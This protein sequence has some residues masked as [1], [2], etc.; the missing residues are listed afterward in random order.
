M[1]KLS[2]ESN[3]A[4]PPVIRNVISE[5]YTAVCRLF[6]EGDAFHR[7]ALPNLFRQVLP[8]RAKEFVE[9]FIGNDNAQMRVAVSGTELSG[10]VHFHVV[11]IAD[12]PIMVS[13][14][15]IMVDTLIVG[16]NYRHQGVGQTLMHSVHQWA[17]TKGIPEIELNVYAFNQ[18][19]ID[20]YKNLGYETLYY[21]MKARL[22]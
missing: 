3:E 1:E 21:R 20:F 16:K 13:R 4:M 7:D 22:R 18:A 11:T 14:T 10:L 6:E 2:L 15:Y 12:R 19:A 9:G 17:K 8:P 5:D